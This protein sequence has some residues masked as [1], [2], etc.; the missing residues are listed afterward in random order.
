VPLP[1][2]ESEERLAGTLAAHAAVY[3]KGVNIV[4]VHDVKETLDLIKV[5]HAIEQR[6]G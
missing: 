5:L 6:K 1:A 4:R 3:Y 2:G